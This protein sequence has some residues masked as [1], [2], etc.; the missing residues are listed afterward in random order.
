M[1]KLL[2]IL[3]TIVDSA[4]RIVTVKKPVER[5]VVM[6]GYATVAIRALGAKDKIVR[7]DG[8]TKKRKAVFFPEL[9]KLPSVGL[10]ST[11]P[12]IE[13]ILSLEP[14]LVVTY[15]Y[16]AKYLEELPDSIPVVCLYLYNQ[17]GISLEEEVKKLGYIFGKA[18]EANLYID[19]FYN[20]H[21]DPIKARTEKL[22][23]EERP[24]VYVEYIKPYKTYGSGTGVQLFID[25][26]GGR[27][28]FVDI[29]GGCPKIDPEELIVRNPDIIIKKTSYVGGYGEDDPSEMKELRDEIMNRPELANVTAVKNGRVYVSTSDLYGL[30]SP[31]LIVY[32]AKW[33]HPDLFEDIDPLG[34][35]QE[36]ID[37]FCTGLDFDVSKQGVF[38]YPEPS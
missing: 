22:S 31:V 26:A 12:D 33:F 4:D 28:I 11:K 10:Y 36:F 17:P 30:Q 34:I 21:V 23:E 35:H 27:N 6:Q 15:G 3:E 37:R 5:I 2:W 32:W 25:M 1:R 18:D 19:D 14:D 16:S 8:Y 29:S 24:K 7:I 13:T 20:K 9:T 38:V